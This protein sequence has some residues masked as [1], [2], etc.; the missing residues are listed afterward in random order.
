MNRLNK[1]ESVV[2][3]LGM[4]YFQRIVFTDYLGSN[5][6]IIG[7]LTYVFMFGAYASTFDAQGPIG[8]DVFNLPVPI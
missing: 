4:L 6:G 5:K 8:V 3:K 2:F 7:S 1:T